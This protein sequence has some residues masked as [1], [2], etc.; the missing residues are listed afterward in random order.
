[1]PLNTLTNEAIVNCLRAT[2]IPRD[3]LVVVGGAAMQLLG[4]KQTNDIDAVVSLPTLTERIRLRTLDSRFGRG[5]MHSPLDNE[6]I[7]QDELNFDV[8]HWKDFYDAESIGTLALLPTPNDS[9][10]AVSF[11]ELRDEA[12]DVLGVLVSPAE[13]VLEWKQAVGRE[14]DLADI[15]LIQSHLA[16]SVLQQ[17]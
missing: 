11:E 10:Y 8:L 2:S 16:Q 15:V 13:R 5:Y 6:R 17:S 14:K 4:I 7:V 3:E 12:I 9:L 1:M